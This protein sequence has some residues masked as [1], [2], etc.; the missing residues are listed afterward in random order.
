M[1][2][3]DI[4]L[5]QTAQTSKVTIDENK[6]IAFAQDYDPIPLHMDMSYAEKTRFGKLI[7]PGVMV[8]MSVWARYTKEI[9]FAGEELIA[10]QSTSM[11]W[12]LPVFAGDTVYGKASITALA[13]RN[14]YNGNVE[15]TIDVF[16]QDDVLVLS[17]VT[18]AVV[19]RRRENE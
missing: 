2:F 19:K 17:D 4:K 6:M 1:F 12:Y 3:E 5:G 9:D 16:N 11:K 15:I 13:P 7:A 10:G 8:F 14:P 18:E